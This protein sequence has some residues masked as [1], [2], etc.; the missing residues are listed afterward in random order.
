MTTPKTIFKKGDSIHCHNEQ[1]AGLAAD[2]LSNLG[3]DW[4]FCYEKDGQKG[5]W[6]NILDAPKEEENDKK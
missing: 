6:I 5:I 4:D 1:I 3:Y 2:A